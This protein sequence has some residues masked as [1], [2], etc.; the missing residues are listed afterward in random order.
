MAQHAERDKCRRCANGRERQ[1]SAASGRNECGSGVGFNLGKVNSYSIRYQAV[2]A[3]LQDKV[4]GMLRHAVRSVT[5][6]VP[7]RYS[8]TMPRRPIG[9][10]FYGSKVKFSSTPRERTAYGVCLLLLAALEIPSRKAQILSIAEIFP[11]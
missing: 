1:F 8:F 4:A 2:S 6:G 5:V 7:P 10:H 11:T 3:A 9:S